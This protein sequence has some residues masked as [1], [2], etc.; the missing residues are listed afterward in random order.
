MRGSHEEIQ[1]T[2]QSRGYDFGE[3]AG[4]ETIAQLILLAFVFGAFYTLAF[5]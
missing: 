2:T 1:P 4:M 3:E 5:D